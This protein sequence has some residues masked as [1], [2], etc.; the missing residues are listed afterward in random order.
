MLP[1]VEERVRA[2]PEWAS[3]PGMLIEPWLEPNSTPGAVDAGIESSKN[4]I[5]DGRFFARGASARW[6]RGGIAARGSDFA[7]HHS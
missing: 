6:G 2:A 4:A 7:G 1:R 5:S 3:L